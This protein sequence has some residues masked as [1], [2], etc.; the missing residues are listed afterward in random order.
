MIYNATEF[1]KELVRLHEA[2]KATSSDY[3]KPKNSEIAL[4]ACEALT[5]LIIEEN[6]KR[7]KAGYK[8]MEF[9]FKGVVLP[10]YRTPIEAWLVNRTPEPVKPTPVE[11]APEVATK[12]K[13]EKSTLG[14]PIEPKLLIAIT[15]SQVANVADKQKAQKEIHT[16]LISRIMT[17]VKNIVQG[18]M[19]SSAARKEE[20]LVK[21]AKVEAGDTGPKHGMGG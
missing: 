13:L 15:A 5:D 20:K 9:N 3:T 18:W 21:E 1:E 17:A 6:V 2:F 19:K 4:A 14:A 7:K 12:P 10:S 16:S 8:Q 11:S